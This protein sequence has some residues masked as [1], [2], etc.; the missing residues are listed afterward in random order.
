M[1]WLA[2]YQAIIVC[3]E[4]IVR[5]PKRNETLII[6]GD[7][8][9]QGNV[10]RLNIISCTK[11]Q[12]YMEKGFSIFLAYVTAKEVEDKSEKKRLEDVPIVRD[13]PEVFPEDLPGLPPTRQVE[14]QIDSVPGA[15]PVARAPYRIAPSEMKEL[16]EQLKELSDKGFIRP[17]SSPWGAPVLFVKKKD[18]SFR[19][20]I[21]YQEL[22]KLTVKN[23]YPLPRI[24][25]LFD[26]LQGSSVYSKID[27]R[28]GYHQ[29]RVREEDIP[30]TAFRT[31]FLPLQ[32]SSYAVWFDKRT[33][34]F[35]DLKNRVCK[36]YLDKFV[37]VFIDDI[38]I[39]S[40]NKEEHEEHLKQILELLKKEELYAKFSKCEFWIPKVQFLGSRIDRKRNIMGIQPKNE[41][42]KDWTISQVT[43]KIVNF[44]KEREPPLRVRALVMTI[45][46]DLPKQILNAQTEARKPENIKNEDVGGMLIEN[47][48]FPEAIREQKLEPRADGYLVP[49]WQYWV[50]A[51]HQRPS[52]LLVQPKI[53]EW[54]WDNITM[55]FVTKL[56]KSS[57]GYDKHLEVSRDN[58][59][60][61]QS[62]GSRPR[63]ASHF[64]EALQNA[65]GI[66]LIGDEYCV[67]STKQI[68]KREEPFKTH[69]DICVACRSIWKRLG[70]VT[71]VARD[72]KRLKRSRIPLVKVRWNSKRGPEFTWEREDQFKKK[73][74]HLFTKTAPSS[75]A[76][77]PGGWDARLLDTLE[78][79]GSSVP[80]L[81]FELDMLLESVN[82]ALK[83]VEELLNGINNRSVSSEGSIR[84]EDHFSALNL[85]C[86]ERLYGDHGLEVMETLRKSPSTAVP[87]ILIR[88]KQ[89]QEEWIKCREDFNKVWADIYAKNH[90]KSLDHRSFYFKQQDSKD[91]STKC[92][93][94]EIKETKEKSQKDDD[95]LYSVAAG[96]VCSTKEQVNQVLKLWTTFLE[97]M[98]YV[99]SRPENSDNVEDV[100]IST[101]GAT[102]N[103]GESDGSP[104]GADSVTF[105]NVKQGRPACNGDDN[106]SP[107][108]VDSSKV[109][110]VN[111]GTLPKEDGSRV[112]KDV[113]N[114]GIRDKAPVVGVVN[115]NL[116]PRS[117]TE[118]SG[119]DAT[120]RPRNVHD[121]GHEAKSNINYVPSS[122]KEA[123]EL[124]P[125]VYFD[126]A[127]LAAYGDHNRS[128]TKA[129]HS[130]EIDA[131]ADDEDSKNVLEGGD[132]VSGKSEGEAEGIEDANFISA[133]GTY[134]DHILLS[135]KPLEKRVASPLHDGPPYHDFSLMDILPGKST[136]RSVSIRCQGYIGDFVLGSHA[137]DMVVLLVMSADSAVTYTSVHSEA[138]SWSIPSED[139][140]EEAARQLLE[141]APH[142]PEYVPDP[143]ELEDH[144]P[145]YIPEPEHPEDLVPAEDEAPTPL[146]PPFFL[147]PRIRPLS[148][149]ALAAEMRDIAS[150]F[151]HSLHPSGTPPLLPIPLPAPST[152][153][154][155]DIPEADTPPRKRLLLT[156]P[157]PSCEVGESSA[158]AAA[159][160]PGPTMAHRVDHSLVDTMETRFRDT[161]RRMMTALE[162]VNRRVSYQV[163]VR[164]RESSEFHSR[165]HDAQKDR[166]AVRAEIEVLRRERLAYAP[167]RPWLGLKLTAGHYE[168]EYSI[169]D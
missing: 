155:A 90:Y 39:Y 68:G 160:Q 80:R 69:R 14:F 20:C 25:D 54:K 59:I 110:I 119:R 77:S 138:R 81:W 23:R 168:H 9:N 43:N 144:V 116:L 143:M 21:N 125:N 91:L 169:R 164:S 123:G 5:I 28:S 12:K 109:I 70:T 98:L 132:D 51:E 34:R 151:H 62:F 159:R 11:M 122:Q 156:T 154:R 2:K 103:E 118:L 147:S 163:D 35:H 86:I 140:Y 158:A 48:K 136:R 1:D 121:D 135:A 65:L 105:N 92:L 71:I 87:V 146:L 8:S 15:A 46:L 79:T 4:K 133:D 141:Q 128:N 148:P 13:F 89:K 145:V 161:E 33:V 27:L 30:K 167:V 76:A 50:K 36:P 165:H 152:S 106:V 19:M 73:Y 47:A 114:T 55:D 6:H 78:E 84:V 96:K 139:P 7:R 99:P 57:Q 29:L 17:S 49:Q 112:E 129:K 115:D 131:D 149:R 88:M 108:R 52:G 94:A 134:S 56:P 72:S 74:P 22:N 44:R 93:V 66:Y 102:R 126:E 153:R 64:M 101:R 38:L 95:V 100:E 40:K 82:S 10:T 18:G 41:S 32:F 142:S 97:P 60:P 127:D 16:S 24:D 83:R 37:I 26:Q 107:K 166:A 120:P 42:I 124:S 67:P 45:S 75:S 104:G 53:P 113:K 162:M 137:K 63:F 130:M 85:R 31:R 111:G 61:S 157:R 117:S 58:G 3:A 150:S